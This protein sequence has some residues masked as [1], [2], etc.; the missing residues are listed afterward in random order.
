MKTYYIYISY[1]YI[2]IYIYKYIYIYILFTKTIQTIWSKGVTDIWVLAHFAAKNHARKFLNY[3]KSSCI[4][5]CVKITRY[6]Q[7][8]L[9]YIKSL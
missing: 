4:I 3:I 6:T 7:R 2:Y 8:F 5:F 9:N 1:I